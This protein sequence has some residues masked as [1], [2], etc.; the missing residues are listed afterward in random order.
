ML[1][2]RRFAFCALCA[3][4][5]AVSAPIGVRAQAPG[6]TRTVLNRVEAPGDTHVTLQV[7]V[8][9][10]AN[11]LV[12][13][14]TH[15]GTEEGYLLEGSGS[16]GMTGQPDRAVKAGD[17]FQVPHGTPHF[18]QNGPAETRVLSVYVVEKDKPL[19][20]PAPDA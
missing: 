20:S 8:E 11:F 10:D 16:F 14:H 13:R 3:A 7:L 12:A 4:G 17:A 5:G 19:A 9:I 6:F 2:R 15:P 18:L 1:S